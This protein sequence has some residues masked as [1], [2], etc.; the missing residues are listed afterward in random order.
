M[1]FINVAK[2]VYRR[3]VHTNFVR[4]HIIERFI[5]ARSYDRSYA[6]WGEDMLIYKLFTYIPNQKTFIDIGAHHPFHISNTAFMHA[7]GWKGINVEPNPILFKKF[8]ALRPHD[9]NLC[10][11]V[12]GQ[13]GTLP[14]YMVDDWSGRNSFD[15]KTVEAFVRD[16]PS[17]RIQKVTNINVVT[18]ESIIKKYAKGRCPDYMTIDTENLEYEILSNYDLKNHGPKVLTME[19]TS[20][21]AELTKMMEQA[22]YFLYI[23]IA[24]NY[25]WV[26]NEYKEKIME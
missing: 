14:F 23:K 11:G 5:G 15:K 7:K 13:R 22:D 1:R 2:S 9:I 4:N 25:T 17:F 26:K 24:G 20:K 8:E 21:K 16:Y 12:A 3:A 18:L 19:I 6:Q 10:C